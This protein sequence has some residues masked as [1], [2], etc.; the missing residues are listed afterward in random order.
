[1]DKP[2][3]FGTVSQ[4][5]RDEDQNCFAQ[6]LEVSAFR[7]RRPGWRDYSV[8]LAGELLGRWDSLLC[9]SPDDARSLAGHLRN[10]ADAADAAGKPPVIPPAF[11]DPRTVLAFADGD[12]CVAL[13]ADGDKDGAV[14]AGRFTVSFS[15]RKAL[16]EGKCAGVLEVP[17]STF[18]ALNDLIDQANDYVEGL[19]DEGS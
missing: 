5:I 15:L 1:M 7:E 18:K 10:A 14:H 2:L 12:A 6:R 11:D 19:E 4:I 8:S 13:F 9:L 3:Y 16:P 17:A